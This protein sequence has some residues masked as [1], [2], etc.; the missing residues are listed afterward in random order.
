[1]NKLPA[2]V[3]RTE[4]TFD[5]ATAVESLV[6]AT[7]FFT[8]EEVLIA[9]ELVDERLSKGLASGY[10]F[11]LAD[12]DGQL[13]GYTC[14]GHIDGTDCSF[15]LF[16]IAVSPH[17]QRVGIGSRLLVATEAE[18]ARRGKARIYIETS[19]KSQY[20]TTQAFYERS[21]YVLEARLVDFYR[22]DDD[23]L[24]YVKTIEANLDCH[25]S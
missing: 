14:Y 23:K 24:I 3:Y 8:D 2:I 7:G 20:V 11:I 13:V 18:I 6:A 19:G 22:D 16:W 21:G 10:E 4:P 9:K 17:H 1:M 12:M 25:A 15:D 5:D